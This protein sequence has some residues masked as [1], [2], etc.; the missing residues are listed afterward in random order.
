MRDGFSTLFAGKHPDHTGFYESK[1]YPIEYLR[2]VTVL[3]YLLNTQE[4][5]QQSRPYVLLQSEDPLDIDLK[6]VPG[7]EGAWHDFMQHVI[8][9]AW[10]MC[11]L[12]Q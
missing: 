12:T 3:M 5:V 10:K 4:P 6:E 7:S 1:T 11:E 8:E 9:M 2:Q